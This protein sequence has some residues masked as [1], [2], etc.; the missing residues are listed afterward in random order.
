MSVSSGPSVLEQS[1]TYP[2]VESSCSRSP[3]RVRLGRTHDRLQKPLRW[4]FGS[5]LSAVSYVRTTY[6]LL[7][8]TNGI[9]VVHGL[10]IPLVKAGYHIP[11]KI[12]SAL[13]S[14]TTHDPEPIPIV[15]IRHTHS[16]ATPIVDPGS[17]GRRRDNPRETPQPTVFQIGSPVI[18]PKS[19]TSQQ[20][21]GTE[22]LE[23]PERPVK[24]VTH[25]AEHHTAAITS[26]PNLRSE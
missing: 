25:E 14:A 17:R 10:S 8:L 11:R 7:L 21:P 16:T 3:S 12:S 24:L 4:L 6:C 18:R 13:N 5:W 20:Q 26:V 1:S 9:Q 2:S 22:I 19:P 23:E 15:N